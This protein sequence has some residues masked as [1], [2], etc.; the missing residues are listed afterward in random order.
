MITGEVIHPI[1]GANFSNYWY[2]G[3]LVPN[4]VTTTIDGT[5]LPSIAGPIIVPVGVGKSSSISST[6]GQAYLIGKK[7]FCA[8]SGN[9]F[10]VWEE[11][12]SSDPGNTK[13]SFSIK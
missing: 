13:G 8:T 3:V 5:V 7:K 9:T 12:L 1:T 2:I 10:G 6:G 11:P 4:G